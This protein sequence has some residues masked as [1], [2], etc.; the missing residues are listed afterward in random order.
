MSE[1]TLQSGL[2]FEAQSETSILDAAI[3]AQITLPYSCKNGRCSTCKCKLV[4]GSTHALYEE[5]GLSA[6]DKADGWILSCVRSAQSDVVLEA[7]DLGGVVLPPSKTLP[8]RIESIQHLAPDIVQVKLRLA[9]AA[10][11]DFIAGQYVEIIG[12]GGVRRSYSLANAS[13]ANRILELHIRRVHDGA[14]SKYWFEQAQVNDLL[15]LNG[16]LGTFFLRNIGDMH[17]VFL[18]TGTGIA[19][20]KA[21]LESMA[22]LLS[23]E[24]LPQSVTILWGGRTTQTL[25][26]DVAAMFERY[27]FVPVLSR[28]DKAWTGAKGYVQDVLLGLMPDL[29]NTAVYA[30]GSDAMVRSANACLS[31]AGLDPKHFYSDAFVSSEPN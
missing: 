5:I 7:D 29:S 28:P 15:R 19:P 10:E 12:P 14:L 18:A 21:I 6:Q 30:C 17:L 23:A 25:Y 2:V 11:F 3:Q 9:P 1:I 16:P 22:Y 27:T 4:S 24:Q 20:I 26:L 13:F 31:K 8:T